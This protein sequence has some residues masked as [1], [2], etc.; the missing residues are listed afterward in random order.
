MTKLTCHLEK[1]GKSGLA[2]LSRKNLPHSGSGRSPRDCT[3]LIKPSEGT[4]TR[5]VHKRTASRCN[6]EKAVRR[7]AVLLCEI[8]VGTE[9][10]TLHKMQGEDQRQFFEQAAEFLQ[11]RYREENCMYAVIHRGEGEP[12]HLHFGFVPMTEDNRLSAKRMIHR[13]ELRQLQAELPQYLRKKGYDIVCG[14]AISQ[15]PQHTRTE[16][17]PTPGEFGGTARFFREVTPLVKP[18]TDTESLLRENQSLHMEVILLER[19]IYWMQ[20]VIRSEP[21]LEQLYLQQAERQEE[22]KKEFRRYHIERMG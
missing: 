11:D 5:S 19:R 17:E 2:A 1:Y 3:V 10:N 6:P 21:Q 16:K 18:G 22:R 12:P 9:E 20:E 7:D 13:A 14:G 15:E 8:T 4:L